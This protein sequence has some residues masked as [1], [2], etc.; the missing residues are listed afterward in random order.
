[1]QAA[2]EGGGPI[3]C[4]IRDASGH[5]GVL[6]PLHRR[7]DEAARQIQ[8]AFADIDAL[9]VA[10]GHHRTA[11][12]HRVRD[13]MRGR[14]ENHTGDEPYN[15]LLAVLFPDDE[16]RLM[17]CH[18]VVADLE[19]VV[20]A[21]EVAG[22]DH[23]DRTT[24]DNGVN[25]PGL[26]RPD[27]RCGRRTDPHGRRDGC[28]LP[29]C[30][31]TVGTNGLCRG[32]SRWCGAHYSPLCAAAPPFHRRSWHPAVKPLEAS[33]LRRPRVML[34]AGAVMASGRDCGPRLTISGANRRC[35]F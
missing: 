26:W 24:V 1:M 2:N 16:L 20:A 5:G 28:G 8:E 35:V 31:G 3:F 22:G 27:R 30:L 10:D 14:N 34:R 13:I 7:L 32:W 18:R 9:Y 12:A 21:G 6:C 15:H 23:A 11:S 33:K 29:L 25:I 17:G 19:V 4:L